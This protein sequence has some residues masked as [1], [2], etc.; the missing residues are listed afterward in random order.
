VRSFCS[1]AIRTL[2]FVSGISLGAENLIPAP[3]AHKLPH[4]TKIHGE[5]RQD[6]Y[7][8]LRNKEDPAVIEYLKAENAYADLLMKGSEKLQKNFSR[9]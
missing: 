8:W 1:P 9:K 4:I 7:Y 2:F 6:D 5:T 3:V